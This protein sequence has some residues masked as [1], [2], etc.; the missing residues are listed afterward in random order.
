VIGMSA[1][2]ALLFGRCFDATGSL[3]Q[4]TQ[5]EGHTSTPGEH[6]GRFDEPTAFPRLMLL[7]AQD[8]HCVGLSGPATGSGQ[9]PRHCSQEFA[10]AM[11]G[12]PRLKAISDQPPSVEW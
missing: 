7:W 2:R 6:S 9:R 1:E 5:F 8:G 3:D 11:D 12:I 10:R 4:T